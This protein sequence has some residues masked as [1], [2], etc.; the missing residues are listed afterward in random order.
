MSDSQVPGLR[1]VRVKL[2]SLKIAR[3][4]VL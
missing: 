1:R 2:R 3:Q 4:H